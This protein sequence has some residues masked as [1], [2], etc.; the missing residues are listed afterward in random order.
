MKEKKNARTFDFGAV[1]ILLLILALP[2]FAWRVFL[3]ATEISGISR[4]EEVR[5]HEQVPISEKFLLSVPEDCGI[6]QSCQIQLAP[7]PKNEADLNIMPGYDQDWV[8]SCRIAEVFVVKTDKGLFLQERGK[9]EGQ[10]FETDLSAA[11]YIG[12][13]ANRV[14]IPAVMTYRSYC[15]VEPADGHSVYYSPG[16]LY[17][18]EVKNLD[19]YAEGGIMQNYAFHIEGQNI[20]IER[21]Y[22]HEERSKKVRVWHPEV[23]SQGWRDIK[24]D[25]SEMFII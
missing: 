5:W 20:C 13:G 24:E 17:T 6:P 1:G 8:K 14:L 21:V 25:I 3:T 19:Q 16:A 4:V 9:K 10:L 12:S 15:M 7:Y 18:H 22:K 23:I 11:G 2:F